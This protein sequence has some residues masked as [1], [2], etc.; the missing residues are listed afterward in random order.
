MPWNLLRA[1]KA[2]A[3]KRRRAVTS[4]DAPGQVILDVCFRLRGTSS[5][6][7]GANIGV[8]LSTWSDARDLM[9]AVRQ[10]VER[11]VE[12]KGDKGV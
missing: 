8:S 6:L 11:W 3:D 2:F 7:P 4:K 12:S 10:A 5:P 9:L 1:S